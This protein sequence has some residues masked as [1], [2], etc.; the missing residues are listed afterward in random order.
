MFWTF[1]QSAL[2]GIAL[3][4]TPVMEPADNAGKAVVEWLTP[5]EHDFGAVRHE[6]PV[7]FVFKFKNNF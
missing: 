3:S 1:L 6:R 5:R 2:L 4:N 7:Q